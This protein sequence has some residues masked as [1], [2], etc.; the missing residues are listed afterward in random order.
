MCTNAQATD[1][2]FAHDNLLN[3]VAMAQL[4]LLWIFE[5]RADIT[6]K[7]KRKPLNCRNKERTIKSAS[8]QMNKAK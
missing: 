8:S 4:D 5:C 3:E 2:I 7:D 6:T 1:L